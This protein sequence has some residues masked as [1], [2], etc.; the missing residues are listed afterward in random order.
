MGGTNFAFVGKDASKMFWSDSTNW[1]ISTNWS[2]EWN[3]EPVS[4][5]WIDLHWRPLRMK[6]LGILKLILSSLPIACQSIP[7]HWE[8][9]F[10]LR[11]GLLKLYYLWGKACLYLPTR[12]RPGVE[13]FLPFLHYCSALHW[14]DNFASLLSPFYLRL[15]TAFSQEK[16]SQASCFELFSSRQDLYQKCK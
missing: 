12:K 9:L 11:V 7:I 4:G 16:N 6:S 13:S 5:F 3:M 2:V 8:T 15:D 1:T 14:W 10:G